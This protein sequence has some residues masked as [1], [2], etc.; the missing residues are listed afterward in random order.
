MAWKSRSKTASSAVASPPRS[1]A[2]P[3]RPGTAAGGRGR[4]GR[5][6]RSARSFSAGPRARRT[7][8][9][10]VG[11]QVIDVGDPP[12]AGQLQRQ[13][14]QQ[15]ADGRDDAGAGVAGRRDQRG[16]VQD[17][18][19]GM[20]SSSPAR[21]VSTCSG[22]VPKSITAAAGRFVS[23]P[24]VAGEMLASRG[25]AQQ[26]AEPLLGQDLRDRGAVQRGALRRQ[27]GGNLVGGQ[28]LPR[29]AITRPRRG[30][31]Q[32]PCRGPGPACGAR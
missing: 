29:S 22:Q 7:R 10:G 23:R 30:P 32:G 16:Q 3:G 4:A 14:G 27:P 1:S 18:R 21:V 17:T 13:Q 19:S 24:G 12:G 2:C 11:E 8:R 28:A 6:S 20:A 9:R 31:G 25:A 26:P 5:S 15:P